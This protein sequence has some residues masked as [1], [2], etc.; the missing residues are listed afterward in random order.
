MNQNIII[1][2]VVICSSC[3]ALSVFGGVGGYFLMSGSTTT[4]IAPTTAASSGGS[5]TAASSGGST[6]AASSGGTTAAPT[7]AASTVSAVTEDTANPGCYINLSDCANSNK[8]EYINTV[9]PLGKFNQASEWG[10]REGA[11]HT[12]DAKCKE[13]M[14]TVNNWCGNTTQSKQYKYTAMPGVPADL[15]DSQAQCY[16]NRYA[17]LTGTIPAVKEYWKTTGF[18]LKEFPYCRTANPGCY[19]NLSDCANSNKQEYINTVGPLGQFNQASEWGY[20]EGAAH[21]SD[22]K[23]KEYMDTVNNWCGNTT[24]SKQYKYT[25]M[26]GVPADLNDSQAQCYKNRY[27]KLT[28][29]IPAVKEYWKTTGFGLKEFPY[30][31]S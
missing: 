22:A 2:I 1:V 30:C 13:Y 31:R 15:N 7:T 26:P 17:K 5:T 19:I 21:T 6:T 9:G 18:G 24:Q 27:A 29:T 10:Y 12:S 16:K 11:A 8:Q 23:C 4:T 20:R 28:G 14:D 25:A 3:I